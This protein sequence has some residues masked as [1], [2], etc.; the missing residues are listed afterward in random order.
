MKMQYHHLTDH[1]LAHLPAQYHGN[2]YSW[3]VKGK[4][5]NNGGN[6]T[7]E[8][9]DFP[10]H[11][12]QI[13][14]VEYEALFW[15]EALPFKEIDPLE[16][17]T[18]INV[19]LAENDVDYL[20]LNHE[21]PFE[22]EPVDDATVDLTLTVTFRENILGVEDENGNIANNGRKYRFSDVFIPSFDRL[23][24]CGKIK[25]KFIK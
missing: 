16:L 19:W 24:P 17:L 10:K 4:M 15:F 20:E 8:T 3:L 14:Q 2:F 21:F 25:A 22:I 12:I 7:A 1:L 13:C 6:I 23:P 9:A 11:S 18:R 5:L